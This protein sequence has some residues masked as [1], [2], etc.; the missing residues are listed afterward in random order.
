M[1]SFFYSLYL[2][3]PKLYLKFARE[4]VCIPVHTPTFQFSSVATG[5][6]G[7]GVNN[8]KQELIPS[9]SFKK[10]QFYNKL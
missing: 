6:D 7:N 2:V 8:A 10:N 4:S 3:L 1:I 9:T 5:G